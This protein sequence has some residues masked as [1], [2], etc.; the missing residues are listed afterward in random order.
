MSSGKNNGSGNG[1]LN[2]EQSIREAVKC[3]RFRQE[4]AQKLQISQMPTN[5][6]LQEVIARG[7]E[8]EKLNKYDP[9]KG[10][11]MGFLFGIGRYVDL[12]STREWYRCQKIVENFKT[13]LHVDTASP[14]DQ[15]IADEH[16]KQL[17]ELIK[18]L[19]P[20]GRTLIYRRFGLY[21]WAFQDSPLMN[22]TERSRL[23]RILEKLRQHFDKDE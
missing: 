23:C 2:Q 12:E 9:S 5:D 14:I 3:K 19:D 17:E 1:K 13:D 22:G 21:V 8:A 7:L 6:K 18:Q 16:W 20:E 4:L 10:T 11:P 15:L